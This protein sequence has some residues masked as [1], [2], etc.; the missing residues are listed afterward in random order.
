MSEPGVLLAAAGAEHAE[1]LSDLFARADVPCHCRFWHFTGT[2]HEWLARCFHA[3]AENRGPMQDALA[4]GSPEMRGV[5]A[6]RGAL[7]VG[8][9]KLSP[10][11]AVKK[12]YN[13]RVYRNLPCFQEPRDGVLALGCM[14]VDPKFRRQ[15][16]ARRMLAFG[17]ERARAEGAR[18]IEAFPRRAA[19]L[20]DE[21]LLAG[22]FS[23]L[24]A[25]GF[26]VVNDFGPYP[27]LRLRLT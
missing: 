17:V 15:G 5:V 25:H 27:V 10:E 11:S 6:M 26:E 14:L 9:M 21:E 12:L 20:R 18:A 24:A 22:P 16:I 8:W 13:Q 19:E 7:V 4:T 3:P 1:A 2:N 23:T